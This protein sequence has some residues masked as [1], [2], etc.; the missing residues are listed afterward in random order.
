MNVI[1]DTELLIMEVE[2][3]PTLC[4]PSRE[5]YRNRDLRTGAWQE[6]CEKLIPNSEEMDGETKRKWGKLYK[7]INVIF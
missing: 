7:V 3:R 6:I 2:L 1:I 5:D 4:D